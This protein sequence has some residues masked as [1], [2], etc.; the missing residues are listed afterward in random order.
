[1]EELGQAASVR[2]RRSRTEVEQLVAG[3]ESSGLGRVE[4]CRMHQLSLSTLAR[5]R[6][7]RSQA[8]APSGSRWLAVEVSGGGVGFGTGSGSGLVVALA[9]G[10]R[11]EIGRGFDVQTLQ[12]L[13]GVLEHV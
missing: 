11:I 5:W 9:S 1:M 8:N 6:K 13:L 3:Y 7:R 10:R 4:F 12:Q 2:R